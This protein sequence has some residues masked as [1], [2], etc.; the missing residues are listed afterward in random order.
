MRPIDSD[1][2]VNGIKQQ[3]C[4]KCLSISNG[5]GCKEVCRIAQWLRF[6][7]KIPTIENEPIHYELRSILEEYGIESVVAL[8][9]IIEQYQKVICE[10]TH[11]RLSKLTYPAEIVIDT[12]KDVNREYYEKEFEKYGE[13]ITSQLAKPTKE[14]KCTAC[15]GLI[16]LPVF[17]NDCYYDYCPNCGARMRGNKNATD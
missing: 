9:Y 16:M 1:E 6:I 12:E 7:K 13:W 4:S 3:V 5:Y 14:W 10:I 2:L 11:G 15:Q 17:T 8:K